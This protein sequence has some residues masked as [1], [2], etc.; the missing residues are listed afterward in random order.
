MTPAP[1]RPVVLCWILLVLLVGATLGFAYLPLGR[2]NLALALLIASAKA[3]IV[4]LAFMKLARGP[5]LVWVFASAGLFW[6]LIMFGL[7]AID[8]G[9]RLWIIAS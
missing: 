8:Y 3:L 1:P 6:L 9:T 2:I 4:L 7:A 5:A